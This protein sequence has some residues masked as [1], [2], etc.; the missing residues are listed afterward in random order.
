MNAAIRSPFI[1]PRKR[2]FSW[3]STLLE[4]VLGL[5]ALDRH[6]RDRPPVTTLDGF[7][8]FTLA[9]LD[10]GHEVLGQ[11][12][13]AVPASGATV[14][15]ANHPF[16]GVEGVLLGR[17][18]RQRRGDVKILVNDV[19]TRI[20]ELRE[21]FIPVSVLDPK[22]KARNA[23]GLRE[24]L[25][26]LRGGGLLLIFPAGMVASYDLRQR[27][28][29]ERAWNRLA[30]HLV[31]RSGAC[32][33]PMFI[34]GR[35]SVLFYLLGLVHF[36]L[37]T[38]L[39][40]R[41]L[42]NR[43]GTTVR[44]H[45]GDPVTGPELSSL[46]DA[47]EI[48]RYLRLA[49]YLLPSREAIGRP[50]PLPRPQAL[51]PPVDRAELVAILAALD[52]DALLLRNGDIAVYCAPAASLTAFLPELA[53][54]RELTF[55][56]AGEGTG[57]AQDS[58]RFDAD[59]L[60]LFLWHEI[61]QEVI[62]AY[63]LGA[64]D[65]VV[66]QRGLDGLYTRQL[67]RY[68][69]A[70]LDGLGTSLEMGRSFVQPRYQRNPQALDL[71]WKGIGAYVSRHR[72][73]TTLFGPVSISADYSA[74]SRQLIMH[75]LSLHFGDSARAGQVRP[76]RRLREVKAPWSHD[77]LAV[78]TDERRLSRLVKRIEGN[79]SLPVLLR[80]YLN[81]S[82]RL[83]CFHVDREFS[84]TLVGLIS[85]DLRRV[86]PRMLKRYLTADAAKALIEGN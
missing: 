27:R 3:L 15:V 10:V 74:L 25:R 8:D 73:Y 36:R 2:G 72:Q 50:L 47:D 34:E 82:G 67:F 48:V 63:R 4:R 40:P 37:R 7:L 6:Y 9:T 13:E 59:Y 66:A 70:F 17:L 84:N 77:L 23:N 71:L 58:D 16:G 30:G 26:H 54:L 45:V 75:S 33:V 32:A 83:I 28:V 20:P 42:L 14:V 62:G 64:T 12:L 43:R 68:D 60:H 56:E 35:N 24:A 69:R 57:R 1:L 19:L 22:A 44:V 51:A 46:G 80:Q 53:R 55:R 41:Q 31:Q 61:D 38:L 29:T 5:T 79:K 65:R 18:L 39:L 21:L 49:T 76:R 85:V 86:E 78:L 11:G 52:A 81:L